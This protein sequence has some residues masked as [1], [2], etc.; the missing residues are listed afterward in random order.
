MKL[1]TLLGVLL[2]SLQLLGQTRILTGTVTDASTHEP[3][4]NASITNK[5]TNRGTR[6]DSLGRFRL[7][8]G[9]GRVNLLISMVGY[10]T[11]TLLP[12]TDTL[13]ITLN[14]EIQKLDEVVVTNKHGKYRNKDNPAVELIRKVIA[15]KD[16]NRPESFDY[17]TYE[18]YDKVEL[19]LRDFDRKKL[20]RKLLKPYT[21]L[22]THPDTLAGED[23]SLLYPVYLEEKLSNNYFQKNPSRT[24]QIITADKKVDFGNL[25]DVRGMSDYVNTLLADVDIYDNNVILFT[26]QFLSPISPSAPAYYEFYLGDTIMNNGE[27]LVRL[28]FQPRNP[29][30]LLFRGMLYITLDG[31]Y[32]VEK[33]HL[34]ISKRINL[35]FIKDLHIWQ[36]FQKT[37][38]GHYYRINSDASANFSLTA[39]GKGIHGRKFVSYNKLVTNQPIPDSIFA[40]KAQDPLLLPAQPDS[41]WSASR[42]EPL[43]AAESR[44][45]ANIDSLR[46][47]KTFIR[48][49]DLINVFVSGYKSA[50]PFEIGPASTFYSFDPVEGFRLRLGGRSTETFSR[51]I[52][53]EGYG[54]YGFKDQKWKYQAGVAYS[55][56][57]LS[58]FGYPQH[59]LK[60]S[61]QHDVKIPGQELAFTQDNSFILSFNR[62]NNDKWLYNDI[63]R[64]DY[65]H[66]LPNHLSYGFGFKYWAQQPAGSIQYIQPKLYGSDTIGSITTSQISAQI[67]WAPHEKFYQGRVYR[68][69]YPNQYPIFFFQ[70][71]AGVKG[72]FG[73]NYSYQNFNLNIFKRF[74]LSTFGYTDMTLSAS[75]ING[76]LPFPLLGIIPAN[77]TY[78]Y[79]ANSYNLMNFLEFVSDHYAGVDLEH[80]FN[81]FLF[82]KVPLLKKLKW[83]EILTA[84]I[85]YGGLRSENDPALD[86]SLVKFPLLE[87]QAS[88]FALGNQPYIEAG[89]AI[90]NIFKFLRIDAIERFGYLNHPGVPKYGVRFQ[91][92]FD[93]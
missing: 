28:N 89:F 79:Q 36:E 51:R 44:V 29:D 52:W 18:E 26:N 54:A 14:P 27:R 11:K 4:R 7:P 88:T 69:P 77:Q 38:N 16:G 75:Y 12:G 13:T 63:A 10:T 80:H 32:A 53:L 91:L 84:K 41:F 43:T 2:C 15:N 55:F 1:L 35:N 50:G 42:H 40:A 74:Y 85:L 60:A 8:V 22:F 59:Y 45:Y 30:D 92:K 81:G 87:G 82:N 21:F 3:L 25:I 24:K 61:F 9:E 86:P 58:I 66:E 78:I 5:L 6:S 47:L 76:K 23:T 68:I 90:G 19:S 72:L 37:P 48:T 17:V 73:G 31:N 62:G 57:K 49:K 67:R 33:V 83:R 34:T 65:L 93:Y 56:N 70:V 71:V 20:D 64:L 39:K 46:H